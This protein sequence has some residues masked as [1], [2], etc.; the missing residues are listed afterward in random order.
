MSINVDKYEARIVLER[1]YKEKI[2]PNGDI[3]DKVSSILKG[4]HKT[5][6][7]VLVNAL[8]AKATNEDVDVFSLQAKD[9]SDGAYDARILCHKVIVPFE[10]NFLNNALGGSNEPFLNKPARFTRIDSD[11]AVR[12]GK[13]RE[14]LNTLIEIFNSVETSDDALELLKASMYILDEISK[15]ID[16]EY[17]VSLLD[18]NVD[19]EKGN[20]QRILDYIYKLIKNPCEGE[21]CPLIVASLEK[22]SDFSNVLKVIPHNVNE[23]G[24]SS[25]EIGDID[26]LDNNNKIIV[27]I[28]V[29]DKTFSKEDVQHAILKFKKGDVPQSMFI[30]GYNVQ[31]NKQE[32]FQVAARLGRIGYFCSIVSII[33]FVKVKL[34]SMSSQ[35]TLKDFVEKLLEY[36]KLINAREDTLNW[37]KD[38]I[39]KN[40]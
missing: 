36:A 38:N 14:T 31:F 27:S 1:C 15:T 29:K 37:I 24:S 17:D 16:S 4:S 5:Y 39:V 9:S 35:V 40:V 3:G 34:V 22:L 23:S 25:K 18:L 19:D 11:N 12:K 6:K 7:Y 13:D 2:E 33:D 20:A 32:V 21:I 10:R 8:L 28:E 30:Y 26:I